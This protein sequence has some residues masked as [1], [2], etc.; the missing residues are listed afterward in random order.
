[1]PSRRF[2]LPLF[3]A[4]VLCA[5]ASTAQAMCVYNQA[6]INVDVYFS[7]GLFCF[8]DWNTEPN[9]SYCRPEE[10]GIVQTDLE[11][12]LNNTPDY[13]VQL[14]V[15]AH[16]YVV[17]SQPSSDRINLCAFHADDSLA[18]CKSFNPNTGV[19]Y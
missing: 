5:F 11:E 2:L 18:G 13:Q 16:G 19:V 4:G 12:G 9:N 8:N 7:C 14:D 10:S 15:D 3:A 1:M 17:I 6:S